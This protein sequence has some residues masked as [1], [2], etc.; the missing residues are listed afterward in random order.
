[1]QLSRHLLRAKDLADG[2]YFEPLTVAELARA[3]GL[4]PAHFSREFRRA[5]GESPH[6]Y[7]LTR[8]LE[9]AAALLRNTD[10]PVTEICF[11]VG[12]TSLG[13]FT[14]SFRRVYGVTPLAY[15]ASFPP[16]RRHIRVPDCVA[17]AYGRPKNRTF[18]EVEA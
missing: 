9:R 13:S 1:M 10:R 6:R 5:F 14:T 17:R 4:S 16:A 15:R 2:R 7:L 8:R 3:A 12:L 11:S 18:R